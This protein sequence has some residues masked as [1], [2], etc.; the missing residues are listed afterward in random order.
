[1]LRW[2]CGNYDVQPPSDSNILKRIGNVLSLAARGKGTVLVETAGGVLSP[3]PSGSYQADLYRALRIPGILVGDARLGGIGATVSA[4]ESLT[5]R[6]LDVDSVVLFSNEE[7]GNAEFLR[8]RFANDGVSVHTL[9]AP[10]PQADNAREDSERMAQYYKSCEEKTHLDVLLDILEVKHDRRLNKLSTISSKAH[11]LIWY[12]FTQHKN[13][14]EKSITMIDSAYGDSFH[15]ASESFSESTSPNTAESED[16]INEISSQPVTDLSFDGSASWWT[17]GLGHGN[18]ELS[19]SAAYAAGRY[20]HVMFAGAIHEPALRLAEALIRG[21]NNERLKKV[22]YTDNGSTGI[23][24]ALKMALTAS[25]KR[26][27]WKPNEDIQV[28]GLKGGYHGDTIGAMD[29]CEPSVYNQKVNWYRGRG[30]WLDYPCVSMEKGHWKL[31]PAKGMEDVFEE[32]TFPGLED[33][34]DFQKRNGAA[35]KQYI[36]EQL[37]KAIQIDKKKLGALVMEPVL[38]GAGG[39]LFP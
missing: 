27:N 39:M 33:I 14:D 37:R 34:F 17:Q 9:P 8:T 19:I 3:A 5:I 6:G 26:Y 28:L 31:K 12:P 23:E 20:G 35:Y 11:D 10:P 30:L 1:M 25:S 22:F 7:F 36:V 21:L 15:T 18:P 38:L 2:C 16:V 32:M 29:C 4:Y 24:V 13:K